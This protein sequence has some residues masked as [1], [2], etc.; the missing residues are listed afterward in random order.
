MLQN[1][2]DAFGHISL[3]LTYIITLVLR[4]SDD[5]FKNE[6]MPKDGYGWF[7]FF[8]YVILLPSPSVYF[9]CKDR[10]A[11]GQNKED[12]LVVKERN[13]MSV[14]DV[15]VPELADAEPTSD[16]FTNPLG[17]ADDDDTDD[18]DNVGSTITTDDAD[19][20]RARRTNK[21]MTPYEDDEDLHAPLITRPELNRLR[22]ELKQ[23]KQEI[24]ELA[25]ENEL[26][27][28]E[29]EDL[30]DE[31]DELYDKVDANGLEI[32]TQQASS[33]ASAERVFELEHS[34]KHDGPTVD[35]DSNATA[36][37][38]QPAGPMQNPQIQ[39][40]QYLFEDE[41]LSESAREA[42]KQSIETQ[43][44]ST[45]Q[46]TE[47]ENQRMELESQ[48]DSYRIQNQRVQMHRDVIR[49]QMEI[50][51][52]FDG[53][54]QEALISTRSQLRQWLV[55]HRLIQHEHRFVEV[56]GPTLT[57][58]DLQF[59]REE[60]IEAIAVDMPFLEK[61]RLT[62]AIQ[63]L[64][65]EPPALPLPTTGGGQLEN[66][67]AITPSNSLPRA[68][69]TVDFAQQQEAA[70]RSPGRQRPR[71]R[72]NDRPGPNDQRSRLKRSTRS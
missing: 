46:Q 33:K 20:V 35:S 41:K 56:G 17:D 7:I 42:A 62:D 63:K 13:P 53:F 57:P 24:E 15:Q 27:I 65:D 40:M 8:L 30:K 48:R 71:R 23:A 16:S 9:Y 70:E 60:D 12:E 34:K 26:L 51:S 68:S 72:S 6:W 61:R 37:V 29:N 11:Q 66:H 2:I 44:M 3:V 28:D 25:N 55:A 10:R 64:V 21:S 54:S 36:L 47:R 39:A 1:V 31:I 5:A 32:A 43:V 49:E 19:T 52:S 69:A 45:I 58:A 4:N 59:C 18:D 22:R 67:L 38:T 50:V 14:N